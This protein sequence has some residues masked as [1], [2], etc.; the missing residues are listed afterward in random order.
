MA[1]HYLKVIPVLIFML[2]LIV[3]LAWAV[4]RFMPSLAR[5][6]A[7]MNVLASLPL[8]GK[9]RVVLIKA[10]NDYLLLGVSPGRVQTLHQMDRDQ[11]EAFAGHNEEGG[12]TGFAAV[13]QNF[14]RKY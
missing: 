1:E 8:G 3:G 5:S 4:K 13:L 7:V 14:S 10:G 9:E 12:D 6:S 2:L 11:M